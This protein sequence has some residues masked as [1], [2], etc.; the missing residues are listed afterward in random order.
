MR[1][2]RRLNALARGRLRARRGAEP[3]HGGAENRPERTAAVAQ[4]SSGESPAAQRLVAI[5]E[6]VLRCGHLAEPQ[7][8]AILPWLIPQ[9]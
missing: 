3:R 1:D 7:A 6:P 5:L 4:V 9:C 8:P 2:E